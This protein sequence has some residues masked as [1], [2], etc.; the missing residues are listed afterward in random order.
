M[1]ASSRNYFHR[2][3]TNIV[4]IYILLLVTLN[5]AMSAC[6]SIPK[7]AEKESK[8]IDYNHPYVCDFTNKSFPITDRQITEYYQIDYKITKGD[9]PDF[10]LFEGIAKTLDEKHFS[11]SRRDDRNKFYLYLFKNGYHIDTILLRR[12]GDRSR[13]ELSGQITDKDI[14]AVIVSYR[15]YVYD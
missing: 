7:T 4:I 6:K 1:I 5:I 13:V 15:I 3:Q 10:L 11:V 12:R 2:S 8:R 9:D 14:D